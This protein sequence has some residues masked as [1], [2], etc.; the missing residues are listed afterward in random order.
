MCRA[1]G[2]SVR[3]SRPGHPSRFGDRGCAPG[4]LGVVF[5]DDAHGTL[6]ESTI[7]THTPV[8]IRDRVRGHQ[9]RRL[10]A[11]ASRPGPGVITDCTL[12]NSHGAHLLIGS[13]AE[14]LI[15]RCS[16]KASEGP[17]KAHQVAPAP[18]QPWVHILQDGGGTIE[19]CTIQNATQVVGRGITPRSSRTVSLLPSRSKSAR[20]GPG[21][22][23]RSVPRTPVTVWEDR[24]KNGLHLTCCDA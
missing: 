19:R 18:V 23:C 2:A 5:D 3:G 15:Q 20:C 17:A 10:L 21:A 14:P 12:K 16:M 4:S 7:Q 9:P 6:E 11:G 8:S 1:S 24:S 22:L 13:G